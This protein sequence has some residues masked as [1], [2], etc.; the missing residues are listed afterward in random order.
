MKVCLKI[1]FPLGDWHL[2][3]ELG[4]KNKTA[5]VT[6]LGHSISSFLYT[7]YSTSRT[8]AFIFFYWQLK[9]GMLNSIGARELDV[10]NIDVKTCVL[11]TLT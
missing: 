11:P 6:V 4:E 2:I 8:Q 10:S 7:G 9:K 1:S 3:F 5:V